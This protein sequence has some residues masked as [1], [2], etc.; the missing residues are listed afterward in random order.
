MCVQG[1]LARLVLRHLVD[2][3][4]LA[5]LALAERL[6]DLGDV[7]LEGERRERVREERKWNEAH[8]VSR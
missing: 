4:L 1:G 8:A 2:S 3:V 6:L 5:L 7:H